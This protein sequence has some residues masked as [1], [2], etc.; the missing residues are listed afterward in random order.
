MDMSKYADP[1]FSAIDSAVLPYTLTAL[2][3]KLESTAAA[4]RGIA[5]DVGTNVVGV[6]ADGAG[7][8]LVRDFQMVDQRSLL[9]AQQAA[10]FR[11]LK[12]AANRWRSC[13]PR[14]AELE[15]ADRAVD[16]ASKDFQTKAQTSDAAE[17]LQKLKE[18]QQRRAALIE[19]RDAADAALA[20]ALAAAVGKL[21]EIAPKP[22]AKS[23]GIHGRT[24]THPNGPPAAPARPAAPAPGTPP[25]MHPSAAPAAGTST[26]PTPDQAAAIA[27]LMA[28]PQQQ[29]AQI[30][31]PQAAPLTPPPAPTMGGAT[32]PNDRKGLTDDDLAA[33]GV[34]VGTPLPHPAG[35]VTPHSPAPV[36]P[37]A[38]VPATSGTS[39]TGLHTDTNTSG[40]SEAPRTALSASTAVNAAGQAGGAGAAGTGQTT[41]MGTPM[42][43]P[44][45]GMGAGGGGATGRVGKVLKYNAADQAIMHG[46]LATGEAVRGGTIAQRRL[47]GEAA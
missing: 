1:D 10:V 11:D 8:Q 32:R 7:E 18:A 24:G 44:V 20:D 21:L 40:R 3:Q 37:A 29:P 14:R 19:Q 26:G 47:D 45:G 25:A 30:P 31:Q 27:A 2:S 9:P 15:D 13:A 34:P 46:R 16:Q 12:I 28:R 35:M 33:L 38:P 4:G 5:A 36:T 22:S 39:S 6:T 23:D 42:I 43:P 41:P 17:A